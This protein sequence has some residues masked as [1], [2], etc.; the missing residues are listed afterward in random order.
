MSTAGDAIM[1]LAGTYP[2]L[3]MR[4]AA[5]LFYCA[6]IQDEGSRQVRE[7]SLNFG[8]ARPVISRAGIKLQEMGLIERGQIAGDRRTCVFTVTRAGQ[9]AINRA[10]GM[11]ILNT[12]RT[13]VRRR[14]GK[15]G[16]ALPAA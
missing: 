15:D 1:F 3:S 2:D 11:E 10:T 5:V 8:W 4:Q 6:G 16:I 7:L 9:Q 13:K 12:A 14:S